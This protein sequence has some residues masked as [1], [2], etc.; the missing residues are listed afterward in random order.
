[1]QHQAAGPAIPGAA[2]YQAGHHLPSANDFLDSDPDAF[3]AGSSYD[4]YDPAPNTARAEQLA[5]ALGWFSI[6]LGLAQLLAPEKVSRAIGVAD[7]PKL[8]RALGAREL[9][10]GIGILSQRRPANWLWGRVAGDAMDLLLLAAAARDRGNDQ[11]RIALATAAVTGIAVL[12]LMSSMDNQQRKRLGQG[13]DMSGYVNVEKSITINKT[14]DECYR[15]WRDFES[16]PRFMRHLESVRALNET[17]IHWKARGPA[18]SSVDWDADITVDEPGRELAWQS[19][20]GADV[21]NAGR[22]LFEFAPGGR[23]TIVR[24]VMHYRPPGGIAGALVAGMFAEEPSVQIDEDLRRFK[25]LIET[26][27]IP[28]T[29][30]QPSG[31]RGAWNRILFRKGAPG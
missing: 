28:T 18:G 20:E 2:P 14:A 7:S 4:R 12:D 24:V 13:P 27:E 5:K 19:V 10:A 26:G 23:G 25:W 31:E 3:Q 8:M 16:F 6:G 17:R 9:S 11:R 29:V 21:D 15:F 30:G 1:M 22:V